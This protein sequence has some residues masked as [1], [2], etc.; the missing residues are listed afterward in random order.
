MGIMQDDNRQFRIAAIK[1]LL[2]ASM[3]LVVQI[4]I[5]VVSAGSLPNP[6]P[7]LYFI[8][9]FAHY[10]I[11]IAV[12]Y[13]FNPQL[14]IR[15]F[16]TKRTGSKMWDEILMR[17]SNLTVIIL[18]P[19]IAGLDVGRFHWSHLDVYFAVTGSLLV[20]AS[21]IL[22]NWAMIVNPHFEPTVRIQEDHKVIAR[23]PYGV[24]RHPGYLAGILFALSIPLL[25][26]SAFTFAPAGIYCLLMAIRTWLE[27]N[28]LQKELK[29][30][31]EY[32]KQTKYRLFPKIW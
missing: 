17:I 27:D 24:V 10:F 29:G 22:L 16:K 14:L 7:W 28:T 15:R 19:A 8:V 32:T 12:Q 18:I 11:S 6:Q 30:Y 5:F 21:S 26:G 31:P 4:I 1:Q 20:V 2:I 3:M 23:G 9:A 25:I 13:K